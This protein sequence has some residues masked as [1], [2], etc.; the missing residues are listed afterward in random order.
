MYHSTASLQYS[1]QLP[2]LYRHL[3]AGRYRARGNGIRRNRSGGGRNDNMD[4]HRQT[5][6]CLLST[7]LLHRGRIMGLLPQQQHP[8]LSW[9]GSSGI[10]LPYHSP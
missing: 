7:H 8:S 1:N 5:T 3:T 6:P 10:I 9:A 2:R 4:D